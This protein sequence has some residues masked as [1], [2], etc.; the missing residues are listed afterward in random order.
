MFLLD[1][2]TLIN[3]TR[4]PGKLAKH[5][6]EFGQHEVGISSVVE[7]EFRLGINLQRTGTRQHRDALE[8]LSRTP[9]YAFDHYAAA[10]AAQISSTLRQRGRTI[11]VMDVLIA[12]HAVALGKV[13]VTDNVK[14]FQRIPGLRLT[15]W[16]LA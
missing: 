6:A 16:K 8:L 15:S 4:H 9:V 5:L 10:E 7:F 13:L 12:G 3:I 11:G 2:D 1:T 14:D